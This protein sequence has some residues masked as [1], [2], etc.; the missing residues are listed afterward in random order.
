VQFGYHPN[1]L[2]ESCWQVRLDYREVFAATDSELEEDDEPEQA[3]EAREPEESGKQ[4]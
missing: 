3:G 2:E 1:F 4:E